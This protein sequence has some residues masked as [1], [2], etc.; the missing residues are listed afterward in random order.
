MSHERATRVETNERTGT[1]LSPATGKQSSFATTSWLGAGRPGLVSIV[2]VCHNDWPDLELAIE[3][4]LHQSYSPV[5]VIVVD[6]DSSDT[7]QA[8][9][10]RVFGDAVRYVRQ[11]NRRAGSGYN[12]GARNSRGE[13]IQLLEGDDA[14]APNK[15]AKQVETFR[16]VPD[17]DI[18][19][20]PHR[21]F[22]S[23]AG[24]HCWSDAPCGEQQDMLAA[25]LSETN[26]VA[27]LATHSTLYRRMALD[28]VGPWDEA[29]TMTIEDLWLRA[30]SAGFRFAYCPDAL[31]FYRRHEG[32]MSS[33][34]AVMLKG[35]ETVLQKALQYIDGPAYRAQ[36]IRRIARIRF[37]IARTGDEPLSSFRELLRARSMAPE[38]ISRRA[39]AAAA[40]MVF[41]PSLGRI[42][43]G[44]EWSALR[45]RFRSALKIAV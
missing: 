28:R 37:A 6:N 35:G 20:G 2:I 24:E 12:T 33:Q 44:P 3:S 7:T 9:V 1:P 10:A 11:P 40:L 5:E 22:F 23:D 29:L 21:A 13:F 15:I 39:V 16:A 32:Q 45:S 4:S 34:P 8:E 43:R 41:M 30:A 36:I 38:A 31:S 18:V 19:Y 25:L 17:A 26:P 27:G 14:L 42:V